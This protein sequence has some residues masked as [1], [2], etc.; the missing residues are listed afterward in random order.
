MKEK[1]LLLLIIIICMSSKLL[2]QSDINMTTHWYNRASYNPAFIARP[3]YLYLFTNVRSQ[4]LGVDGAPKTLN[5]EASGYI[6]SLN[7]AFGISIVNDKIGLTSSI[8]PTVL[9]AY[10]IGDDLNWSLSFGLSGGIVSRSINTSDFNPK[11]PS[12][13]TLYK[14]NDNS[15]QPDAN[16]GVEFENNHF[17]LGISSTHLFALKNSA[18]LFLNSNHR[19]AYAIYKNTS[20]EMLNYNLGL[21]MVNRENLTILE[22]NARVQFRKPLGLTNSL[23]NIFD[24]GL[25]CRTSKMIT[26]LIGFNIVQDLHIGYAYDQSFISGLSTYSTNEI[27]LEYRIPSII[28]SK[29]KHCP[30]KR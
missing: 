20:N 14:Y 17:I 27:M 13:P 8:N 15:L 28:S 19:Y 4:W 16:V 24:I 18:N 7:S 9:Y 21:Q 29:C 10:R 12:D 1:F 3:D 23:R 25:T 5:V 2:A 22:G 26:F 30:D 11:T 6:E